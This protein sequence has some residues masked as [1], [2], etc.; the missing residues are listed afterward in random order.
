MPTDLVELSPTIEDGLETYPGLP[1]PE[2]GFRFF[3]VPPK[4]RRFT[5][6][7]VRAFRVIEN[8]T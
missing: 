3:A 2:G 5:S 1:L 8:V 7:P 4:I 6:F